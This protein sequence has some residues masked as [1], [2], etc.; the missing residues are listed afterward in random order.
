M[1]SRIKPTKTLS[2]SLASTIFRSFSSPSFVARAKAAKPPTRKPTHKGGGFKVKKEEYVSSRKATTSNKPTILPA[3]QLAEHYLLQSPPRELTLPELVPAVVTTR[4][5]GTA[6]TLPSKTGSIVGTYGLP[7]SVENEFLLLSQPTTVIRDATLPVI[8]I[9]DKGVKNG[10]STKDARV[11]LNSTTPYAYDA[12]TRTF[13]QPELAL[14]TLGQFAEANSQILRDPGTQIVADIQNERLGNFPKGTP[15]SKL[16]D[17]GL[18]DQSLATE[19]LEV[20]LKL[21]GEQTKYPVLIAVDD[22]QALFCMSKYRDPQYELI[23]SHHFALTRMILEYAS[24]KRVLAK[25][26]V[27]GANSSANPRFLEPLPL[28]EALGVIPLGTVSPYERRNKNIVS[29]VSGLKGLPIPSKMRVDEAASMFDVWIQNN[30]LHTLAHKIGACGVFASPNYLMRILTWNVNGIR[31]LSQYHPWYTLKTC[32]EMLKELKA[33]VLCFQ[34]MKIS[35]QLLTTSF[36]VPEGYDAIMSFPTNKGGYS[37]VAVYTNSA[38]TVPLKAEEGL[39]GGLQSTSKVDLDESQRISSTYPVADKLELMPDPLVGV[40]DDLSALDSEGRAVVVDFGLFVLINVYCPNEAS[41]ER[42]PFKFNFH[43][44]LEE[45][46]A[47]LLWERR[48]VIVVGDMNVVAAPVD[49]CDGSLESQRNEFW[50]RPVR[51]WY[52]QWLHP[53]GPMVDVV[54]NTWPDRKEM[55]TCWNMRTNARESN[56]GTRIDYILITQGLLPWFK[57]GDIQPDIRGSDHCPVFIELY[58]E[59]TLSDGQ[60]LRLVDK[61]SQ[62]LDGNGNRRD[63]PPISTK[64]WD[65]YSGKQKLLSS[66]FTKKPAVTAPSGSAL[67]ETNTQPPDILSSSDLSNNTPEPAVDPEIILL[68]ST[69]TD[70]SQ[71]H[72]SVPETSSQSPAPPQN[73]KRKSVNNVVQPTDSKSKKSKQNLIASQRSQQPK[74]ASFFASTSKGQKVSTCRSSSPPI[75]LSEDSDEGQTRLSPGP[76]DDSIQVLEIASAL[77]SSQAADSVS[78]KTAWSKLM[79]PLEPPRCTVHNVPTKEYTAYGSRL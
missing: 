37:G 56:Y 54:R 66:F 19:I 43:K 41:D 6:V 23:F 21:L 51:A 14:Q 73:R 50:E 55:F 16:L 75:E 24:G 71:R 69:V 58:D 10:T 33:D 64:F 68:A 53:E 70:P 25:G 44:M 38:K 22:F 60:V 47:I 63:P 20:T 5:T 74:L 78:S 34:E 28:K 77:P 26:A 79:K 27:L 52:R 4:A 48:E 59:I 42:L 30:A 67:P 7:L 62:P 61:L 2:I 13:Q 40:P 15:L 11:V 49:H 35:R 36:A 1:L 46:V 65:E 9:L 57:H 45:R 12:R 76:A 17:V 32:Q 8:D 18:K 3:S 29:Y 31:T 72:E 39:A